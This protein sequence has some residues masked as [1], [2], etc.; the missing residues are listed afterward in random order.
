MINEGHI[1][2]KVQSLTSCG[3]AS[4]A[5]RCSLTTYAVSKCAISLC[6]LICKNQVTSSSIE[7]LQISL[8]WHKHLHH[9]VVSMLLLVG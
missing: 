7:T 6:A 8:R 1:E 3:G 2:Q 5:T 4:L 9:C